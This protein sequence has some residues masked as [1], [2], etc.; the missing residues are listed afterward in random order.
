[1]QPVLTELDIS[2]FDRLNGLW[3]SPFKSIISD[4]NPPPSIDP[5][6]LNC[7]LDCVSV[8]MRLRLVQF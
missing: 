6:N 4:G 3:L 8:D 2:M 5:I 7:N 1:M